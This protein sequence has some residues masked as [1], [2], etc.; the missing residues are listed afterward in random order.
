MSSG[1]LMLCP[2][3]GEPCG[4]WHPATF[5]DTGYAEGPGEDFIGKDGDWY[6]SQKCLAEA[7][8]KKVQGPPAEN[9]ELCANCCGTGYSHH[10]CGEDSC[11]C[12]NPED[13]VIC[14]WCNGKG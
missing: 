8:Q 4:R 2:N 9:S 13:N 7:E 1:Y 3:C 10:D 6:C 11:C 12:L 14:D 5:T